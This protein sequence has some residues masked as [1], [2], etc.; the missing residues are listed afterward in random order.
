MLSFIEMLQVAIDN[1]AS[2]VFI[3]AGQPLSDKKGK[4]N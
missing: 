2:D 3:V 4:T 1:N